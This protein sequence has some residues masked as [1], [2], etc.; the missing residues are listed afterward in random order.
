M[1]VC[2]AACGIRFQCIWI[3]YG[4]AFKHPYLRIHSPFIFGFWYYP[5]PHPRIW[6]PSLNQEDLKSD[7]E[8]LPFSFKVPRPLFHPILQKENRVL[9]RLCSAL[10]KALYIVWLL[11]GCIRGSIPLVVSEWDDAYILTSLT[12]Q[13]CSETVFKMILDVILLPF[14]SKLKW[15]ASWPNQ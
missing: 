14:E 11:S 7:N 15:A 12:Y 9:G 5:Y 2:R 1:H 10:I 4:T 6:T 8:K 3:S 13:V